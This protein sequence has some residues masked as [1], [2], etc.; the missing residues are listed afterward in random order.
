MHTCMMHAPF[1]FSSLMLAGF[2]E[3]YLWGFTTVFGFGNLRQG[4]AE[5][6]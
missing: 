3:M 4:F 2:S 5:A 6:A 1:K